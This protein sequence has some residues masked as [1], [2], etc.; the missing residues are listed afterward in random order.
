M[1]FKSK[2]NYVNFRRLNYSRCKFYK[3]LDSGISNLALSRQKE[4]GTYSCSK[5]FPRSHHA[6]YS[7]LCS[8]QDA[9]KIFKL[10]R[11][12]TYERGF[13]VVFQSESLEHR[14]E[15]MV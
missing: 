4:A 9:C 15:K 6:S 1:E 13:Q 2:I 10:K 7:K 12:V 3:I 8:G 11:S 14:P 5:N